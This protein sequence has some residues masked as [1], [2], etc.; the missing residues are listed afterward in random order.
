MDFKEGEADDAN[1]R[2]R[3]AVLEEKSPKTKAEDTGAKTDS[4]VIEME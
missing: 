2:G 1:A 3:I 4:E